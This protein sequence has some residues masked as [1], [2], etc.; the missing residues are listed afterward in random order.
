MKHPVAIMSLCVMVGFI[1]AIVVMYISI[2]SED[3]STTDIN[4]E[5]PYCPQDDNEFNE[6]DIYKQ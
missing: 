6:Q 3:F 5:G 4:I 2:W 1:I